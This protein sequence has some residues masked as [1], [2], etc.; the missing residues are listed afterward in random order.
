MAK[1]AML[2]LSKKEKIWK[3]AAGGYHSLVNTSE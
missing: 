3:I 1:P 2:N